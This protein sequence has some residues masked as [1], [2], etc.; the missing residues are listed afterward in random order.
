MSRGG[1][2]SKGT[3]TNC[4]SL[5]LGLCQRW[6]P[7]HLWE[8]VHWRTRTITIGIQYMHW[9]P[10]GRLMASSNRTLLQASKMWH[11]NTCLGDNEAAC[12]QPMSQSCLRNLSLAVP[13]SR[14]V[15]TQYI[16]CSFEHLQD[17][18]VVPPPIF[19]TSDKIINEH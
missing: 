14:W 6:S 16:A 12:W 11:A 17:L 19:P 3:K 1:I 10:E 18:G 5:R 2:G 7:I 13:C 15:H 9:S 4:V 8:R